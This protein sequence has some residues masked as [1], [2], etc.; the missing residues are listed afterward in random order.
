MLKLLA[1]PGLLRDLGPFLKP[2][3]RYK[4]WLAAGF[5]LS[6]ATLAGSVGLLA[7]SGWFITATA[8]A[9]AAAGAALTF[10]FFSPGASIRGFAILRTAARYGE[11]VVTHEATFRLLADLR[12]WLFSK[13]IPLAPARL[14]GFRAGDLLSRL[15][16]DID[17]LDGLY[18]RVLAPTGI[19]A[20]AT[21]IG[22]LL[23]A[24]VSPVIALV[25]FIGLIACGIVLPPLFAMAGRKPGERMTRTMA[26]LRESAVEG[27]QGVAELAAYGAAN[28]QRA[29]LAAASDT[30]A[31]QQQRM[32]HLTGLGAAL[33]GL[34]GNLALWAAL[35]I[36]AAAVSAG[37]LA[38][39][40]LALLAFGLMALFEAAAPMPLAFQMLGKMRS[41][42]RRLTALANLTPAT[43]AP[44]KP[45]P[46]PAG[47]R[48]VFSGV[49]FTHT[50]AARPALDSIDLVLEPGQRLALI[51][52]SGAGKSTL[53]D[54]ALRFRDP[55]A[56]AVTLGG[57]D[58]R[59]LDPDAVLT[60]FAVVSQ[61]TQLFA[62][63]LR[64]NLALA[65]PDASDDE[66]W[67]ALADAQLEE[68]VR[69]LPQ[70]L[71]TVLGEGESGLSGG[72]AR[73][74]AVARALLKNAPILILDEPTTGLDADTEARL[75]AALDRLMAGRS[76]LHITHQ[77]AR[78]ETM[79]EIVV[80]KD[81]H[82]A[83]RGCHAELMAA[84]GHYARLK[85]A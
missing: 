56:G 66:L 48:L 13:A 34:A 30:L 31:R 79:D 46:L 52:P 26:S 33:T 77:L 67:Q 24:L 39:A 23:M 11:R 83:E 35:F 53:G 58:L 16:A 27:V 15:T 54:L 36:G 74:L 9:G 44:A 61:R 17:A 75:S 3:G 59:Q 68:W 76:V 69:A 49:S 85:A 21:L 60:R 40:M 47:N 50:G 12:L 32:A 43:S 81:G 7:L 65:R 20:V 1:K 19:F 62:A 29:E 42:A 55:D 14:G 41:A 82:I 10:D 8:I 72:Q 22:C 38:P 63:T 57:T 70:G 51:G 71:D 25:A 4:L 78:L 6:L 2:L 37:T 18:L 28:R 80:L 45:L 73:R 64:E 5:L 84:G